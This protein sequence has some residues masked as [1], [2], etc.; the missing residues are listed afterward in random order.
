MLPDPFPGLVGLP[1]VEPGELTAAVLG[2]AI[3]HHGGVIVR[4]FLQPA[5]ANGLCA[6]SARSILA[7]DRVVAGAG[8]D[9]D[10]DWYRPFHAAISG[11]AQARSWQK[12]TGGMLM[13]D[14]P[15][16]MWE[17]L[18]IVRRTGVGNAIRGYLQEAPLLS[19]KKSVL[20]QVSD[21]SPTWHQDGSFM[22]GDVR[23]GG[24]V[25]RAVRLRC[26]HR[27]AG[28]RRLAHAGV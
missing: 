20:R 7:R 15:S 3:L 17:V 22:G 13:A 6:R 21:P 11:A 26:R 23:R 4:G 14:S 19:F 10:E 18:E 25:D 27:R 8:A 9:G 28:P 5:D 16:V 24:P 12:N 2:G 1:E